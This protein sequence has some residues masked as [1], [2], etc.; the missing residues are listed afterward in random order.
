MKKLFCYADRYLEKSDWRDIAMLKF[1]LFSMGIF[2]GIRIPVKNR[3]QAGCIA[4][5]VFAATY[6]PLMAK[7]ISVI[8]EEEK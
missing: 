6:I 8:L 5:A 2:A 4:A 3:K 1:C 7:F